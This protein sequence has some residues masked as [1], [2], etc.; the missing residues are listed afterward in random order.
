MDKEEA[1]GPAK[2]SDICKG[3]GEL[4]VIDDVVQ[5][6]E[7]RD[8]IEGAAVPLRQRAIGDVLFVETITGVLGSQI[9]YGGRCNVKTRQRSGAQPLPHVNV[10]AGSAA[11][12][13]DVAAAH[14]NPFA[15]EAVLDAGFLALVQPV[16]VGLRQ[17]PMAGAGQPEPAVPFFPV[18]FRI[19]NHA[20][21]VASDS[22]FLLI[23][24]VM[25]LGSSG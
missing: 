11:Q 4:V 8:Q 16:I 20:A 17:I 24:P 19:V 23:F 6:V 18:C 21:V 12:L 1:A 14:G 2:S 9:S 5:N 22:S 10:D 15:P 7:G 25:V 13:Q 3:L